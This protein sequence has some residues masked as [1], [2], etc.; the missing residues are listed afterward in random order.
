M[1]N[2]NWKEEQLLHLRGNSSNA[3]V[4]RWGMR[5]ISSRFLVC[6]AMATYCYDCRIVIAMI[7]VVSIKRASRVRGLY[8]DTVALEEAR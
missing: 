6:S 4:E 5:F 8:N 7:V 3:D 2:L 1:M